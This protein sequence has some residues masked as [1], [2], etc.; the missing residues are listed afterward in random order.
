MLKHKHLQQVVDT[1]SSKLALASLLHVLGI[2]FPS[3]AAFG[4]GIAGFSPPPPDA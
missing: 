2:S 1:S 4:A 3:P